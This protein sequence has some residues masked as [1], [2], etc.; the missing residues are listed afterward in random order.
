MVSTYFVTPAA[1]SAKH[2]WQLELK[3]APPKPPLASLLEAADD[4]SIGGRL[5][6]A[7]QFGTA[8]TPRE[9]TV[10]TDDAEVTSGSVLNIG[11]GSATGWDPRPTEGCLRMPGLAGF[12]G[13][14]VGMP[15]GDEASEDVESDLTG[16]CAAITGWGWGGPRKVASPPDA[17]RFREPTT[18]GCEAI[19]S[20]VSSSSIR[21]DY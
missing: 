3:P 4:L 9:G 13:G 10:A 17:F 20:A 5:Q 16:V 11:G 21:L 15:T 8:H 12:G 6:L 1:L 19:L 7:E 18:G 14:S 2:C